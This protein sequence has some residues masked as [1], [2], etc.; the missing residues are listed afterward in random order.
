MEDCGPS[1]SIQF[2]THPAAI[3]LIVGNMAIVARR[4]PDLHVVD[5]A[6]IVDDGGTRTVPVA[7]S[8]TG[9]DSRSGWLR[10][11]QLKER[12]RGNPD[13][14]SSFGGA[15]M[16]AEDAGERYGTAAMHAARSPA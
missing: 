12:A 6:L 16:C 3:V 4:A 15:H 1:P 9:S 11:T 8:E 10:E 7:E 13:R 2:G 14:Q 5:T